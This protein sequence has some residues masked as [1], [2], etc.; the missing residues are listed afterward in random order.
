MSGIDEKK[1]LEKLLLDEKIGET[2]KKSKGAPRPKISFFVA[3]R[4]RT[5]Q[6]NLLA[7]S[8][9]IDASTSRVE[10]TFRQKN[11]Q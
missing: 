7:V 3:N 6:T 10:I 1:K 4:S 11:H 2:P 8:H 9:A 5:S